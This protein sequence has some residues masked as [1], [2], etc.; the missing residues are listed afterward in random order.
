[1]FAS[2]RRPDVFGQVIAQ[3]GSF[4]WAPPG[5]DPEWLLRKVDGPSPVRFCLNVGLQ[6]G[7]WM[8][9]QTQRLAAALKPYAADVLYREY[10]GGHDLTC[11]LAELPTELQ[12][13]SHSGRVDDG[14]PVRC[15][16]RRR[17]R[18]EYFGSRSAA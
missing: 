8:I 14:A 6:V 15:L 12:R 4:W 5:D 9:P 3:S 7:D 17:L 2:L 11:W 10:S 18:Q 13:A 16:T 1:M